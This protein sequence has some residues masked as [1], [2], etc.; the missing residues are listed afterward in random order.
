[1]HQAVANWFLLPGAETSG[2]KVR[3][4]SKLFQLSP[5]EF[6]MLLRATVL[7]SAVRLGL[8]FLTITRLQQ[9]GL[10]PERVRLV[11]AKGRLSSATRLSPQNIARL[12]RVAAE[13]GPYHAKCL[14]QSLVLHWLLRRQGVDARILFGARKDEEQMLAHAWVEVNGEALNEDN[15]VHRHFLPFDEVLANN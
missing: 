13:H 2:P 10:Q 15:G 7:L 11:E 6:L 4:L 14:E 5:R 12:V 1:M 8:K 9:I 3:K